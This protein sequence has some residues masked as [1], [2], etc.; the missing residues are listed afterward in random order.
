MGYDRE[1][2]HAGICGVGVVI[3]DIDDSMASIAVPMPAARFYE[4]SETVASAL[5]R[6]R[7]GGLLELA[8]I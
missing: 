4:D 7:D 6:V 8:G 2:H 3:S 5:L 1:E